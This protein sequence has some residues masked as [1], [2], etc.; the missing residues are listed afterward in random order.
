MPF[1]D[2]SVNRA[3][4]ETPGNPEASTTPAA[5]NKV[6]ASIYDVPITMSED[7]ATAVKETGQSSKKVSRTTRASRAAKRSATR[8]ASSASCTP[9]QPDTA[10]ARS[11]DDDISL[12]D[13]SCSPAD[14]VKK[15]R[16]TASWKVGANGPTIAINDRDAENLGIIPRKKTAENCNAGV[17]IE[18]QQMDSF[19][20][21]D[22]SN[23]WLTCTNLSQDVA[24]WKDLIT[25]IGQDF[26][27]AKD[28]R[29]VLQKYAIAHRFM[30]KWKK[31]DSN[32]ASAV[33]VADGCSWRIHASWV[34]S[35]E[36]FRIKKLNNTHTC[37]GESWKSAHPSKNWLVS[38]IK[39][40]LRDSPI[41]KPR[42]IAKSL[43]EDFGLELNYSQIRRG[44]EDAK[45]Q[46]Q[47]S[48]KDAYSQLP[49]FC[50]TLVEANPLSHAKILTNEDHRF[51]RLFVAFH[52]SIQ[53]FEDGCRPLLYLCAIPLRSRYHEILVTASGLDGNDAIFP[54]A[55]AIVDVEN[56]DNWRWFLEQL[57]AALI[58]SRRLT[59]IFDREKG[60]K[61]PVLEVFEN[62]YIGYSTY[63]LLR[64]FKENLKGPFHGDGKVA[65]PGNFLAAAFAVRLDSFQMY[66]EQIKQVSSKAYD[67]IMQVEPEH[68]TNAAFEG[69]YYNHINLNVS[70]FYDDWLEEARDLPIIRKV[71]ILVS[72]IMELMNNRQADSTNWTTKL[73]PSKEAKLLEEALIA[74]RLKALFSTDTLFEV[75]DGNNH[76]VDMSKCECSCVAWKIDG[77]PCRHAI[78]VFNRTGRNAYDYCSK[79]FTADSYRQAYSGSI[80][81]VFGLSKPSNDE[82]SESPETAAVLPPMT[83]R[84]P[85]EQVKMK[86]KVEKELKREMSCSRCK[87]FGH[88]K[89]T[90]KE[91]V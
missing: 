68:W 20:G 25:G 3:E 59:F 6:D 47:G 19:T 15:R 30:Y 22:S 38:V 88:N 28:F 69:E 46:I 7:L 1:R 77:L 33:C 64:S 9:K 87:G 65:L 57:K 84:P 23:L 78:A 58:S 32:R 63:Q 36:A 24:S 50:E 85:G 52:A 14:T 79:Y 41:C 74:E 29:D 56:D 80:N 35:E 10:V 27:S 62:A 60:L 12:V 53:G 8:A 90:C 13:M 44:I 34:P 16:R 73:T 81:L 70:Q 40:K 37:G 54:V 91:V 49:I 82:G 72:R 26:E 75:H 42:E 4:A 61:K 86:T 48:Y 76:I 21:S 5:T 11:L 17:D 51:Q 2:C 45:A 43:S 71:D 66:L 83:S 39:D 18:V 89:A 67:W 55:M 31:N